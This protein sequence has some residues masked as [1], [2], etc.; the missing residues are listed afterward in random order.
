MVK[1]A[2]NENDD[3]YYVSVSLLCSSLLLLFPPE[4]WVLSTLLLSAP[5]LVIWG[6]F[7]GVEAPSGLGAAAL[8]GC[9]M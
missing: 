1:L 2:Y 7:Q 4:S 5:A 9:L 3:K 8:G 6:G